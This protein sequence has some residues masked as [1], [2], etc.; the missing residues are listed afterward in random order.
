MAKP[1]GQALWDLWN[2]A[3]QDTRN[4]GE[5]S[6][7]MRWAVRKEAGNEQWQWEVERAA[8]LTADWGLAKNSCDDKSQSS[9]I[10]QLWSKQQLL[11]QDYSNLVVLGVVFKESFLT[12]SEQV[13]IYGPLHEAT[14]SWITALMYSWPYT[15]SKSS[16]Y[17][18]H[19]LWGLFREVRMWAVYLMKKRY[20]WK[21]FCKH[22]PVTLQPSASYSHIEWN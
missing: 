9:K 15:L 2:Q 5:M 13:W 17:Q 6:S 11:L 10:A 21:E 7:E 12:G 22:L 19:S 18:S 3:I 8:V 1:W 4:T 20:I 14:G 16:V